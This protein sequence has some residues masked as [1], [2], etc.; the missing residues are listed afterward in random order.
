[1]LLPN[2]G[3]N[4]CRLRGG[5]QRAVRA[6][7]ISELFRP[8]TINFPSVGLGDPCSNDFNDPDGEVQGAQ[9]SAQ[10][11]ALCTAQGIPASALDSYV[12]TNTQ[13]QGLSGGNPELTEEDLAVSLERLLDLGQLGRL[14]RIARIGTADVGYGTDQ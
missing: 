8:A 13:F 1:M 2:G 11:A 5:Y 3:G 6:P 9:D 4:H 7:N 12:F 10:A 14:E